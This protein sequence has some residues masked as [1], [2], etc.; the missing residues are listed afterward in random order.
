MNRLVRRSHGAANRGQA[1]PEFA[2]VLPL[3]LLL[4]FSTIEFGRYVYTA[5]IVNNAARE[6]ARYAI[7]HGSLSLCPS[8]PMPGLAPNPCD[9]SGEK[10][11]AVV[12]SYAIGVVGTG[13][14]FPAQSGC[15]GG[16]ANPCWPVDNAR[17]SVVTVVV[18]TTFTTLIPIV[19]LPEITIDGSSTLVV[20]H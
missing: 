5:Q 20:N 15:A 8:G 19:P 17:G 16:I 9:A 10:V 13:V 2:L 14:A 12:R 18:R 3:F 11:R 4:L 1:L 6:G 7:T